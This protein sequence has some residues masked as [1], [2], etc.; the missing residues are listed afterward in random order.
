VATTDPARAVSSTAV[1]ESRFRFSAFGLDLD[2]NIDVPRL[3][4]LPDEA[5]PGLRP[6]TLRRVERREMRETVN[7]LKD[8]EVVFERRFTSRQPMLLVHR[9]QADYRIWA[10]RHGQYMVSADG[11]R[12][13]AQIPRSG[14]WWWTKLLFAQVLPL[15]ASLQGLECLHAGCVAMDGR[16][17]ALAA[18]SGTGKS[19]VALHLVANGAR[20]VTDD[21]LAAEARDHGIT[22]YPGPRVAAAD[23]AEV[24]RIPAKHRPTVVAAPNDPKTY[25][26]LPAVDTALP[27]A[28][29]YFLRRDPQASRLAL[30]ESAESRAVLGSRFLSYLTDSEQMVRHLEMSAAIAQHV[31]MIDVAIPGSST[32][33]DVAVALAAH[34]RNAT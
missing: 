6:A 12:V 27:L 19:S 1:R 23:P 29:I 22:V 3:T 4:Q 2:S 10:P 24:G 32:A 28:A 5:S 33:S 21:I 9:A 15:A 25:V 16:A 26:D 8:S 7:S 34:I 31:A 11:R 17:Y 18:A 30:R 13:S 14:G 20:F